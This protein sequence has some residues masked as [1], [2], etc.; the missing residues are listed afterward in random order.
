M[1][2]ITK[3]YHFYAAHRNP[4]AGDKCGRIH[5]HTYDLS[6]IMEFD[7]DDSISMLF[8]DIDEVINPIV[9]RHDHYFL[10]WDQDP[11]CEMLEAIREP[12]YSLPFETSA[13]NLCRYFYEEIS[14]VIPEV[15]RVELKETK[16]SKVSYEKTSS[17]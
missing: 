7:T 9:K 16:S 6:V 14:I 12:Y 13:E 10:V 3:E 1:I 15:K 8:S 11:L 17:I 5:G 4:K 2:N